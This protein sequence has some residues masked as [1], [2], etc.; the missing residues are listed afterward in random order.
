MKRTFSFID[1]K[2]SQEFSD[3]QI[4]RDFR[5]MPILSTGGYND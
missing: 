2:D 4:L 3:M 1:F 5:S